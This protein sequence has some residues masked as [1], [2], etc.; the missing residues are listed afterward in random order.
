M[1]SGTSRGRG[2]PWSMRIADDSGLD[3]RRRR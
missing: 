3:G 2:G 1:T